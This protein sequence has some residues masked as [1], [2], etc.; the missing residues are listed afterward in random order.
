MEQQQLSSRTSRQ[1]YTPIPGRD[2]SKIALGTGQPISMEERDK[3]IKAIE[4]VKANPLLTKLVKKY[5]KVFLVGNV[6]L[7]GL[8]AALNLANI[9][10][11]VL[12]I[13]ASAVGSVIYGIEAAAS[14]DEAIIP[15]KIPNRKIVTVINDIIQMCLMLPSDEDIEGIHD[16]EIKSILLHIK[17]Y[18][19][20]LISFG[21]IYY[22]PGKFDGP[23]RQDFED[24]IIIT[25]LA[26]NSKMNQLNFLFNTRGSKERKQTRSVLRS[27]QRSP[28]RS[29]T[30]KAGGMRKKRRTIK[31]L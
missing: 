6:G 16:E 14:A 27:I 23:N 29:G 13:V 11:P 1:G 21:S 17:T 4:E 9:G 30:R 2:S 12:G 10:L 26:I 25:A 31:R 20:A 7:Q 19:Q 22:Q 15:K 3:L 18:L 28:S 8:A 5:P 24:N